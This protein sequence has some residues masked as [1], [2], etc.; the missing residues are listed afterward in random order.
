MK[1]TMVVATSISLAFSKVAYIL[2]QTMITL[3]AI[4]HAYEELNFITLFVSLVTSVQGPASPTIKGL[5]FFGISATFLF[6]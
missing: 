5:N 2:Q 4:D 1:R 3:T 6:L